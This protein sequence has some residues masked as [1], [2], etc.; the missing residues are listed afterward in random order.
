MQIDH[1]NRILSETAY[2]RTG[3]S[4]EEL[5]AAR[6]LRDRLLQLGLSAEIV[7]FEVPMAAMHRAV[8]EAEGAAHFC[9]SPDALPAALEELDNGQ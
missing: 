9:A 7:P 8:L 4:P 1:I 5:R 3:G 6:Y 2:V